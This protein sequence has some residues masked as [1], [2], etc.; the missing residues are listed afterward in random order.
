MYLIFR[1][2]TGG[3]SYQISIYFLVKE[4]CLLSWKKFKINP[5]WNF[6]WKFLEKNRTK[7]GIIIRE[8]YELFYRRRI[9][10]VNNAIWIMLIDLFEKNIIKI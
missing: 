7:S 9:T 6:V 10:K 4:Y 3:I 1:V 8:I 5:N 2:F